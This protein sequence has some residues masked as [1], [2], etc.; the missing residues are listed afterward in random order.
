MAIK[1]FATTALL[2]AGAT[3]ILAG[4]AHAESAPGIDQGLSYNVDLDAGNNGV[5]TTLDTGRFVLSDDGKA[6]SVFD[7]AGAEIANLPMAY[8]VAGNKYLLQPQI[9]PAGRNLTL[10]PLGAPG[11]DPAQQVQAQRQFVDAAADLQR[12]Q[13]NAGVGALIGLG[14]GIL[15]GLPFA[16]VGAIP[17]GV[18]GAG[19]GALIGWIVP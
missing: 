5:S 12:H 10:T 3:G 6:V 11:L 16:V 2:A 17:G 7:P 18:I 15:L 19:I 1:K 9:D 13:Y 14:V 4:T 8:Q